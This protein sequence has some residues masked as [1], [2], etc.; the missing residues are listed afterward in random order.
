MYIAIGVVAAIQWPNFCVDIASDLI[1]EI[2]LYSVV[3]AFLRL[4]V[5]NPYVGSDFSA[6]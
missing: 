5:K 4:G 3:E 1:K 2:S 6:F